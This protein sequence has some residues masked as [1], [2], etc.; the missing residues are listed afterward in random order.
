MCTRVG[1]FVGKVSQLHR[2]VRQVKAQGTKERLSEK[3][4]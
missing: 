2:E 1:V 3:E 4:N